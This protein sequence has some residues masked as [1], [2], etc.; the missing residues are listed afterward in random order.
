M[1][2]AHVH[3]EVLSQL[4]NKKCVL[5]LGSGSTV[6]CRDGQGNKG[7][8]G[9]G[10]AKEILTDLNNGVCPPFTT[11]LMEAAEFYAAVRAGARD[12]LDDLISS[13]LK[14]LKPTVGHYLAASFPWRSVVT[15]NYNT[16]A[17]NA[18]GAATSAAYSARHAIALATDAA[19]D[20]HAGNDISM[21]IYKP[22]GCINNQGSGAPTDPAQRQLQRLVITSDDYYHSA[23][24][25]QLIYRAIMQDA[26]V[27]TTVFVG[28]SLED[29]TF[30]NM[31]FRLREMLGQW[32]SKSYS[33]GPD[34][35]PLRFEWRSEAV[36][37]NFRTTLVNDNFDTFMLRLTMARGYIHPK[38]RQLVAQTWQ[39][40]ATDNANA[41]GRLQLSDIVNLPDPP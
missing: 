29:Y 19:F 34:N 12:K 13:R 22:H 39:Q 30:R 33:V 27:S 20:E 37:E 38:L 41:M 40:T 32:K 24:T 31:F 14:D 23:E 16:V 36:R 28:Y 17:E 8:D 2:V 3:T 11:T 21:R 9:K 1:S 18:W 7:L 5:F 25:R 10:L 26:Q 15:T 4:A 6:L 35:Q